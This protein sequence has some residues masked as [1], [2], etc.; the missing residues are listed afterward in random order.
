[1]R[2]ENKKGTAL[3]A[4]VLALAAVVFL[5]LF[6]GSTSPLT[7]HVGAD[8]AFFRLV[9]LGMTQGMLPYRDFF[10][11]KGP[12]LF[13]IE[14]L[15]QLICAGRTGTFVMQCV[16]LILTLWIMDGIFR[17]QLKG[18]KYAALWEALCV[19]A[20]L[21]YIGGTFEHG[22]LTEEFSLPWLL[23][24]VYFALRYL[25]RV[26]AEG[27]YS[28]PLAVGFYYGFA[29]GVLALIRI[30]NAAAIGAILLTIVPGLLLKKEF[31]NLF[32]NGAMFILGCAA[33]FAPMC[34]YYACHGLLG[35]MLNQV[36]LFGVQYSTEISLTEKLRNVITQMYACVILALLPVVALALRRVRNWQYWLLSVSSFLL[37]LLAATMGN[38]YL[39]YFVLGIPNLVLGLAFLP[40]QSE[41]MQPAAGNGKARTAAATLLVLGMFVLPCRNTWTNWQTNLGWI[42]DAAAGVESLQTHQIW[43]IL[44]HIPKSEYDSVYAYGMESCSVWY[45]RAGMLPAHRYCDW[46]EHYISLN[47]E[48]GEELAAWL[49]EEPV[50][51]IVIPMNYQIAPERIAEA[52]EAHYDVYA[53]NGAYILLKVKD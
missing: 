32:A 46:Q 31:R 34:V 49:E 41:E 19:A 25:K 45:D 30:T 2:I 21:A 35:E 27:K 29:F 47:P 7:N 18:K 5:L 42:R 33:A 38:A 23:L 4:V 43:G 11:M 1:M 26:Q 10:D 14:Y 52:V 28:H 15:G 50:K 20:C 39:H 3:R 36:F 53:D 12:W 8:S 16:S 13:L 48:I 37:L 9:G 40:E 44:S 51:W 6:S 22:N 17:M 24:A